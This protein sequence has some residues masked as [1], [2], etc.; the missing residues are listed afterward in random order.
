[1]R[2]KGLDCGVV[3]LKNSCSLTLTFTFPSPLGT[4]C[5][6]FCFGDAS[7]PAVGARCTAEAAVAAKNFLMSG[8]FLFIPVHSVTGRSKIRVVRDCGTLIII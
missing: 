6:G 7:L 8:I 5:F 3:V 2:G 1:M 4:N